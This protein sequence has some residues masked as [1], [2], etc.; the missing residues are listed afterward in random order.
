[1]SELNYEEDVRIDPDSLDVE[2][3][4]QPELMLRYTRHSAEMK[5]ELDGTKEKL[6]VGRARIE[7]A[8]RNDPHRFG[9]EKTTEGSISS[10]ILQQKEYQAL[11]NDFSSAKYEYEMSV[12]AVRAIDQRKS[13]L[14]NLVRLLMSSYFAGPQ[15]PRDLSKEVL[16]EKERKTQNAKI[17]IRRKKEEG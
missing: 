13:A 9:L 1:M 6:D 15:A 3:I 8:I 2:W 10:M 17:K 4:K 14:E 5:K 7:L 11:T 12:A 16:A